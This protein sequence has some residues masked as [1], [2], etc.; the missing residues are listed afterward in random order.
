M[1]CSILFALSFLAIARPTLSAP[2]KP[3]IEPWID[4]TP[5][6]PPSRLISGAKMAGLLGLGT[7]AVVGTVELIKEAVKAGR[8]SEE[9]TESAAGSLSNHANSLNALLPRDD[10]LETVAR[11]SYFAED[12]TIDELD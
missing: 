5:K 7:V 3:R 1:R 11:S 12:G 2:I 9:Y 6:G 10:I 4:D 8:R